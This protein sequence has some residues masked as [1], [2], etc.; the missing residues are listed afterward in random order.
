VTTALADRW[1]D[2][3]LGA[4]NPH[5]ASTGTIVVQMHNPF[6]VFGI[7]DVA[8]EPDVRLETP[9]QQAVEAHR[10]KRS[11]ARAR[12]DRTRAQ[13]ENSKRRNRRR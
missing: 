7:P 4:F 11:V 10:L 13:R 9:P 12:R 1:P 3:F 6:Q 8:I 2:R 5:P